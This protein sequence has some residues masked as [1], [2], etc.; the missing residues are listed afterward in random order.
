[1]HMINS[2]GVRN[3]YRAVIKLELLLTFNSCVQDKYSSKESRLQVSVNI[4]ET[5]QIIGNYF[6]NG[7]KL[8]GTYKTIFTYFSNNY[9]TVSRMVLS[10]NKKINFLG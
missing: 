8:H 9:D 4:L 10:H 5:K 1:M 3:F 2:R 6:L 7:N